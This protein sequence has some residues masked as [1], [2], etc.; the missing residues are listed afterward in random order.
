MKKSPISSILE[1][2][3]LLGN[4]IDLE[5]RTIESKDSLP[6]QI[7]FLRGLTDPAPLIKILTQNKLSFLTETTFTAAGKVLAATAEI[8]I[9][10]YLY[11]GATLIYLPNQEPLAVL[12]SSM[13]KRIPSEPT[14]EPSVRGPRDGFIENIFDN[15][16]LIRQRLP[17]PNLRADEIVIGRRTKTKVGVVYLEDIADP[18]LIIEVKSRLSKIDVDGVLEPGILEEYI[19]DNKLTTFPLTLSSERPDKIIG[20]ILEGRAV[21]LVDY[22]PQAIIVPIT[23][24]D[25]MTITSTFGRGVYC[26]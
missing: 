23:L 11:R 13:T 17:D 20:A 9:N 5:I 12:T 24:N 21:I 10:F 26:V 7:A 4:P 22:C 16:S 3:K 2:E 14:V 8:P 19:K 1:L 18:D 15:L 6:V 25:R